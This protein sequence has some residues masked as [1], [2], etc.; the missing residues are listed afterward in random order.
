MHATYI[1][2]FTDYGFKKLFGEEGSKPLLLSFLN[3]L[4]A[5]ES[6]I[7]SLSFLNAERLPAY[8]AARKAVYDLYCE[9]AKGQKFVVELQ[10]IRQDF[11]KDRTVYYSTFPIQEQAQRGEWNFELNAVY[12]VGILGF[13]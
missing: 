4:L 10:K 7:V 2:P 8:A 3:D 9:D 1:H 11:F 6:P 12:C 13:V 5:L